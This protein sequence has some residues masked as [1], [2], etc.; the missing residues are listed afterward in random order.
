VVVVGSTAV[1]VVG[2]TAAAVV[3]TAAAV[4]TGKHLDDR[5]ERLA[6]IASRFL[7]QGLNKTACGKCVCT[8]GTASQAAEKCRFLRR[9]QPSA[10][11]AAFI[12]QQL[13]TA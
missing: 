6:N 13:C 3:P 11:K 5:Q 12:T 4:D 7:L 10:A 2:S 9:Q 8:K 1:A